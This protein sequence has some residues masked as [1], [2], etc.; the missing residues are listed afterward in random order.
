LGD[1]VNDGRVPKLRGGTEGSGIWAGLVSAVLRQPAGL[2]LIYAAA[3]LIAATPIL[4]LQIGLTDFTSLPDQ[5][6]G[7]QAVKLEA[8]KWPLGETSEL[9]V[10]ITGFDRPDSKA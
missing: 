6:D 7:V 4:R 9:Q 1:R 10:V 5:I 3:L 8:A 2:A